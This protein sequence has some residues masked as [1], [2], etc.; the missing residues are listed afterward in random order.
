MKLKS[1]V[2]QMNCSDNS[3]AFRD[4]VIFLDTFP[5]NLQHHLAANQSKFANLMLLIIAANMQRR[6]SA[7]VSSAN[8]DSTEQSGEESV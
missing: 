4:S 3:L 7:G 6:A 1:P 2:T 8:C 5:L